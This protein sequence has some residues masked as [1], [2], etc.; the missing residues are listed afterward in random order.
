MRIRIDLSLLD[1]DQDPYWECGS[2]SKSKEV[3]QNL[4]INLISH[5]SKQAFEYGTYVGTGMF[6]ALI[7]SVSDPG[8]LCRIPIFPYRIAGHLGT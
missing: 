4:L 7:T 6:S 5:I 3:Y 1:P 2:G 8:C